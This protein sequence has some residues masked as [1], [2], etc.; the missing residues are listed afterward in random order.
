MTQETI[1]LIVAVPA[2]VAAWSVSGVAVLG[3][4]F[5]IKSLWRELR[6]D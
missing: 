1:N 5:V 6:D 4:A 2:I 3:C